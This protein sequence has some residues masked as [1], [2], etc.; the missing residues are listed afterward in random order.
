M[1]TN[2]KNLSFG[3]LTIKLIFYKLQKII[4]Q[5]IVYKNTY[6]NVLIVKERKF[7][8]VDFQLVIYFN[9]KQIKIIMNIIANLIN[10]K[11]LI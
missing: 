6:I 2:N 9:N 7:I 11:K 8:N 3:V 4:Q 5:L 1:S 10:I